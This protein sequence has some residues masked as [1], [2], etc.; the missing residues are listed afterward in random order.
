MDW[1]V[2]IEKLTLAKYKGA[3]IFETEGG[4]LDRAREISDRLNEM[5]FQAQNSIEEFRLRYKIKT[6]RNP[7]TGEME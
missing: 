7:E 5:E 3:L 2:F 1:P 4:A 6:S